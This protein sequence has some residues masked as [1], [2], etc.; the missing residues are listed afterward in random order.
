MLSR[1]RQTSM[2]NCPESANNSFRLAGVTNFH[3]MAKKLLFDNY[4]RSFF[5][6]YS[7]K[8]QIGIVDKDAKTKLTLMV[9]GSYHF[10]NP[11][12]DVV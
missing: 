3:E 8:A 4:L 7:V 9:L 2:G 1:I 6:S 5:T 11:R 10:A 12:R